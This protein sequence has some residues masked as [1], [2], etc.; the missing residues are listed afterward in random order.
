MSADSII[1]QF[2]IS[3]K[4]TKPKIW[5]RIQVPAASYTFSDLHVAIQNA[6]GWDNVHLHQFD[7]KH[8]RTGL[9]ISIGQPAPD[10]GF[11]YGLGPEIIPEENA[12]VSKYFVAEKNKA[13]YLYDF[14][15]GWAHEIVLE[16]ILPSEAG[17]KYPRCIAGKRACP[18]EDCGGVYGYEEL[19]K[20]IADPEHEEYKEKMEW[21]EEIGRDDFDPDEFDPTSVILNLGLW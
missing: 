4:R 18:P 17:V 3:L 13:I 16:K 10:Y 5:R 6:M 9:K 11:D 21:L 8:P 7:M 19:L 20:I 1:Y 2:K 15:D 14:G 12:K